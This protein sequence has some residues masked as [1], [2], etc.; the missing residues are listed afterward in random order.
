MSHNRKRAELNGEEQNLSRASLPFLIAA[1][2]ARVK[3]SA[4]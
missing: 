4:E 3:Y 2:F 1:L